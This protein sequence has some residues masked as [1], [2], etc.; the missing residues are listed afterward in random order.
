MSGAREKAHEHE[1]LRLTGNGLV[2]HGLQA[3]EFGQLFKKRVNL[4]LFL[5][6]FAT[7]LKQAIKVVHACGVIIAPANL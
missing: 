4:G 1:L 7:N 5:A 3:Q 2:H 6:V